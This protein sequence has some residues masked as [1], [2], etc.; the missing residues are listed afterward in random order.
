MGAP[1]DI[2]DSCRSSR[3]PCSGDEK[4]GHPRG[5]APCCI[6]VRSALLSAAII[7]AFL[8]AATLLPPLLILLISL[9]GV[10][11]LLTAL[12]P[13]ALAA[14]GICLLTRILVLTPTLLAAHL[15]ALIFDSPF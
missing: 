5:T 3:V 4:K 12:L 9:A 11:V 15:V 2:R 14:P 8:L 7:T 10:P 6:R 13:S 1:V